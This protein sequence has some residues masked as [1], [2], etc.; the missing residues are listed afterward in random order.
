[1]TPLVSP[2]FWRPEKSILIIF[3]L[4]KKVVTKEIFVHFVIQKSV[5][6]NIKMY[7]SDKIKMYNYSKLT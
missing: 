7:K 5:N 6:V 3:L 1:M 4:I 2:K